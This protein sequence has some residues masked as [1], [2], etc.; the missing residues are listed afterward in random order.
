MTAD[1]TQGRAYKYANIQNILKKLNEDDHNKI[2]NDYYGS[3][4]RY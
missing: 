1:W 4:G 3:Y 2:V